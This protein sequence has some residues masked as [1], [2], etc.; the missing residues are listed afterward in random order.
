M[1]RN[2]CPICGKGALNKE[3]IEERFEY[4]GQSISIPNYLVYKCD[5]CKGTIVDKGTLKASGKLLKNFKCKVD[6]LLTGDEIKE[7]RKKLNLTQEQMSEILGG[8]LKG[9]ARYESG[10]ICQSRAMDNLL[11]ILD[12]YPHTIHLIWKGSSYRLKGHKE[13]IVTVKNKKVIYLD[14]YKAYKE[15]Y[16][17]EQGLFKTKSEDGTYG[18]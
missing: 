11:R 10:Q 4:K 5:A 18:S 3:S 15:K 7:I 13:G 14:E 2:A 17:S 16:L 1:K 6:G 12:R 8:G 9:F